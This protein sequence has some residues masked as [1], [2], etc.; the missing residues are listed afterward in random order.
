MSKNQMSEENYTTLRTAIASQQN[1]TAV[2]LGE[3][4]ELIP[5]LLEIKDGVN[6]CLVISFGKSAGPSDG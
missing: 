3:L 5:C 4:L 1:V 2:Y 6:R